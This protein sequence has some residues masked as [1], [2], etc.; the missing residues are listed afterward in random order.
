M[1]AEGVGCVGLAPEFVAAAVDGAVGAGGAHVG[2]ADCYGGE[3][4][5]AFAA[6]VVPA[7]DAAVV[8]EAAGEARREPIEP[9]VERA[10][11]V[12]SSG[13]SNTSLKWPQHS[14]TPSVV[15]PQA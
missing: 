10:V 8:A 9:D 1:S 13:M 4:S 14:T 12:S 5:L 15:S 7:F 3:G 6:E 2:V 11:K